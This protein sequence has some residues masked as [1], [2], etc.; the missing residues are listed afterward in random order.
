MLRF[1]HLVIVW[2]TVFAW[3]FPA[4]ADD[5]FVPP[6][7][8]HL[9]VDLTA[10][11]V[12]SS[13][14]PHVRWAPA[15]LTKMMTA[16]TAFRALELQHLKLNSPVRISEYALSQP[17]SKMGY[18]VGTILTL[19]TALKIIMVKSA[20][21]ISVAIAE[22]VAGSEEQFVSLM[23]SHARRL[24]MSDSRFTNPHGLH[25]PDQFTSAWD[26]L[27]LTRALMDEFP[28]HASFFNIPAIRV[29]GRRLRNHNALLRQFEGTNG[30]KTGYVCA[31]GFNVVVTTTRNARQLVAI[32][33]GGRSGLA[34]N[35][36]TARLLTE[37]F[38]GLYKA[39]SV[40]I[41]AFDRGESVSNI[42]QDIT[43]RVCP[44]KYAARA[45]PQDRPH[46]APK[47]G[48]FDPI[49]TQLPP[50][51]KKPDANEEDAP[52]LNAISTFMPTKRPQYDPPNQ[53]IAVA[54]SSVKVAP[55][56]EAAEDTVPEDKPPTLREL[57]QLYLVPH[58]SL[59]SEEFLK[60]GGG[61]GPNP[62]GIKHTDGGPYKAPIPVPEK[63]PGLDLAEAE[64]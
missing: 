4:R 20:N 11:E 8:P 7:R 1:C 63:R 39:T 36:K 27:T 62:F 37:G 55:Q 53:V 12:L 16:Y 61:I 52:A 2:V 6:E 28:Q 54:Q 14:K 46:D 59:R 17:P 18:P 50:I 60:L 15:S 30:M 23:N 40:P 34:R 3:Q 58:D 41:A 31:S 43:R 33:F 57:A 19:E 29:A 5:L 44:G 45:F 13:E 35:V 47:S 26:M 64:E 22:G 21:D 42:P 48:D 51:R 56:K 25:D 38:T 49:D 9:L 10:D 24:G 32:V